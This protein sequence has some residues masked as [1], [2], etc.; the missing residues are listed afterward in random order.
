MN[1]HVFNDSHGFFLNLTVKRFLESDALQ[2]NLFI[3][4]NNKTI[5]TSPEV[6]YLK[7]NLFSFKRV[8]KTLPAIKS[9]T[10][11]PFDYTAAFFLKELKKIQPS[12]K[13]GWV[14]WG[15]EFYQHRYQQHKL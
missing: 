2:N 6:K 1:L 11:Y 13:V 9:V 7:R 10:F 4:L 14:F 5:Y 8:I 15:Y 3:N 12:I